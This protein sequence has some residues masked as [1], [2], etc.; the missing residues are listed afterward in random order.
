MKLSRNKKIF[1]GSFLCT[2]KFRW[3]SLVHK[4]AR[5]ANNAHSRDEEVCR[6]RPRSA[7]ECAKAHSFSRSQ[8]MFDDKFDYASFSIRIITISFN[9]KTIFFCGSTDRSSR[10]T[11]NILIFCSSS[12]SSMVFPAYRLSTKTSA[13]S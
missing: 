10:S 4:K 1:R 13:I 11:R 7:R 12:I 5:P 2:R 8:K 9:F 6:K 3:N